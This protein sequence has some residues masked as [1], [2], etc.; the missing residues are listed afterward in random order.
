[1]KYKNIEIN[2]LGHDGFMIKFSNLIIY[3][4]P[5][6]LEGS[7]PKA[8]F[9]FITHSHFDHFSIEDLKIIIKKETKMFGPSDILSQTRQ[10][11]DINFQIV[12]VGKSLDFN[13]IKVECVPAYNISKP[14]HP[15]NEGW[16][17]YIFDFSGTK[18]YHTG[19]SDLIPEMKNIKTNIFLVPI[20]GKYVMELN[21]AVK[22]CETV[23][24][25]LAIPM[26]WGSIIGEKSNAEKFVN[27][28]KEK[29]FNAVLME[30]GID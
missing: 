12:S 4:D 28:C 1:M 30:K 29:G 16:M 14:F 20:S 22:A 2:W 5:F 26:H 24:P 17:G 9:I 18:V 25:D 7:L 21:E 15:K 11:G 6:K 13:G 23:K 3:I 19:D 8:D 10:V 27:S